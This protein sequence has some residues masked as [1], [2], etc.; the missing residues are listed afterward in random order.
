MS[1]VNIVLAELKILVNDDIRA[2]E[3]LNKNKD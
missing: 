2:F 3:E 1:I